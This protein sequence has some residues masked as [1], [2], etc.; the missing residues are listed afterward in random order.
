MIYFKC[1]NSNSCLCRTAIHHSFAG[2]MCLSTCEKTII[3]HRDHC[4]LAAN[5]MLSTYSRGVYSPITTFSAEIDEHIFF[6]RISVIGHCT[7][8]NAFGL[9]IDSAKYS[10][11]RKWL[12]ASVRIN[13]NYFGYFLFNFIPASELILLTHSHHIFDIASGLWANAVVWIKI[14]VASVSGAN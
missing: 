6:D 7:P 1:I 14:N 13:Y 8:M 11:A 12:H 10:G 4:S 5:L 9:R 2:N 3:S